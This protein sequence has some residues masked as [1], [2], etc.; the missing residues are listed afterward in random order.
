MFSSRPSA[1]ASV[2][3]LVS[4]AGIAGLDDGPTEGQ[5]GLGNPD[6]QAQTRVQ[7]VG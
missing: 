3:R 2:E 5:A 1:A 7:L 4:G 6:S